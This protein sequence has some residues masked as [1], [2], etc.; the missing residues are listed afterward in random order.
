VTSTAHRHTVVLHDVQPMFFALRP[1]AAKVL[2]DRLL[3]FEGGMERRPASADSLAAYAAQQPAGSFVCARYA[4]PVITGAAAEG[5]RSIVPV[6]HPIARMLHRIEHTWSRFAA[7]QNGAAAAA[8][9]DLAA[10][11]AK[12]LAAPLQRYPYADFHVAL[13]SGDLRNRS[14]AQAAELARRLAQSAGIGLAAFPQTL[15]AAINHE[16]VAAGLQALPAGSAADSGVQELLETLQHWSSLLPAAAWAQLVR[17]NAADLAFFDAIAAALCRQDHLPAPLREH[18]AQVVEDAEAL[19]G[20]R[21]ASMPRRS[22]TAAA[23]NIEVKTLIEPDPVLGW[24]LRA[25]HAISLTVA[26]AAVAMQ[27]DAGGCRPVPG[28]PDDAAR[29]LAV[30]GCSCVFG[31][32]VPVELTFC[33]L[34]QQRLPGWRIENHG[35]NGYGQGQNLLQ[36]MRDLRFAGRGG[37]VTF[38]W[39]A[40]HLPRNVADVIQ[41]QKQT[42]QASAGKAALIRFM[43]RACL[44]ENGEIRFREVA[45]TRPE[46]ARLDLADFTPD[47]HYLDLVCFA[48]LARAARLVDERGGH[49]FVTVLL[50]SLSP[51]LRRM[52]DEAGIPVVD[53]AVSG[54][55]YINTLELSHPNAAAN[56]V[57][58]E[59]IERHLAQQFG[60][61]PT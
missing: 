35:V 45:Y 20:H 36:L 34:L 51:A 32:A 54:A 27:A 1:M 57:Y 17:L 21:S 59:R 29:T 25:D 6:A 28:Q 23:A 22:P 47:L 38:C 42:E 18:I 24:R 14:R 10:V 26:D 49:F 61:R 3:A 60:A 5:I 11:L 7:V 50:D 58:A 48:L 52:L 40:A 55:E 43:P 56:R 2:G 16:L 41:V 15:I 37:H 44:D 12:D 4:H 53:A 8:P 19:T 39:I 13:V 9:V 46:L 30:Y 33:A 31:W